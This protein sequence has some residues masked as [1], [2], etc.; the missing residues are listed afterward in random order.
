MPKAKQGNARKA[1]KPPVGKQRARV[2]TADL[3]DQIPVEPPARKRGAARTG[4]YVR[5]RIRVEDGTLTIVDTHHVDSELALP[6]VLLG[7][8]AYDVTIGDRLLHA[9]SIPDVGVSRS[10]PNPD[11]DA[12][13]EQRGHHFHELSMYEF[14]VRLPVGDLTKADLPKVEIAYYRIKEHTGT[15]LAARPLAQQYEK[16]VREVSRIVGLPASVLG[17]T[18]AS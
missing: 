10:F 18:T 7:G 6:T 11:P 17:G 13:P 8:N 5:L 14:D 4:G 16:E 2:A 9:D 1:T 12:P 3:G 15:P